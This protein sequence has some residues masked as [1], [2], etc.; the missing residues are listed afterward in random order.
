MAEGLGR[1]TL[2]SNLSILASGG[3]GER[4]PLLENRRKETAKKPF[5]RARPLWLVPFV[6]LSALVRGMTMA[7]R[8]EVYTQLACVGIY[9]HHTVQSV[10]NVNQS[11]KFFDSIPTRIDFSLD[12][13]DPQDL[14]PGRHSNSE[15][16]ITLDLE[17]P[18]SILNE[19]PPRPPSTRCISDP[20]AQKDAA[21]IQTTLTTTMGILSALSTGWW[22]HFSERHGRTRVLAISTLG[23]LLTDSAFILAA[24]P[25]S[26]FVMH[27]R[28]LLVVGPFVEGLLGGWP[29]L[30]AATTAYVSDCTSPGSRAKIFSRFIGIFFLGTSVGPMIGGWI[31]RNGFPGIPRIGTITKQGKSVTEVFWLA[32][33]LSII[34]FLLATFFFPE[35]LSKYQQM[36]AKAAYHDQADT[37]G[38]SRSIDTALAESS[39]YVDESTPV[40]S[41]SRFGETTGVGIRKR[42]DWSLTFLAFAMFLFM[43]SV[44]LYQIKHLYAVHTYNWAP[45]ELSYYIS[46]L[47]GLRSAALLLLLP[48]VISTFK[49]KPPSESLSSTTQEGRPSESKPKPTKASLASE[50]NFDLILARC[51]LLVDILAAVLIV[52]VPS[53][54]KARHLTVNGYWNWIQDS[55]KR[56][57]M[58]FVFASGLSSVGSGFI[59]ACQSLAL[60]I[61]QAR[62]MIER[63]VREDGVSEE[64]EGEEGGAVG[65][66]H[67]Q[68][69]DETNTGK[70]LGALST[71]QATGQMILGPMIF[72][73]LYANTVGFFPKAIFVVAGGILTTVLV[74]ALFIRSPLEEYV[75]RWSGKGK[76]RSVDD[77][78]SERGRSRLR[79][80]LFNRSSSATTSLQH[81]DSGS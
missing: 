28:L 10:H 37:K 4:G 79:K 76:T 58:L 1:T 52:V 77:D 35:S 41:K 46:F 51:C 70:L 7:P 15:R 32:I 24:T 23:L 67:K 69:S 34:N 73:L 57:M 42:K 74:C 55:S 17:L 44:G 31:I 3:S 16:S 18:I 40:A 53:P 49:P 68:C 59:P 80:D 45:D 2:T 5:Y 19:E 29:T 60:C 75:P 36:K 13:G 14:A 20:A 21:R 39:V 61:V 22:G 38:K 78:D 12:S 26:P 50:I 54:S 63:G 81:Q 11:P 65:E 6:I 66:Q 62:K 33:S 27:G 43:I 72:G 30:Q 56:N 8:V 71:L 9:H 25:G 64:E 48:V 47:A